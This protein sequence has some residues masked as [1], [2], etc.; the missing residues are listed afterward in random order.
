MAKVVAEKQINAFVKGLITEASPL[1]FPPNAA[2]DIENFDLGQ[3]GSLFR[4]LGL[5]Y[6]LNYTAT[7]TGIPTA[8]LQNARMSTHSWPFPG[9]DTDVSIGVIRIYNRLWFLNLLTA[10]PS[11][12]LLNGG[13][14]ITLSGL[15]NADIETTVING[16]LI[17]VS[18]EL[19]K[20]IHLVYDVSTQLVSQSTIDIKIRDLF[21]VTDSLGIDERPTSL[22]AAHKYNLKNQGW[23][24]KITSICGTD[25]IDCTKSTINT[26][27]SNADTWTLG[28]V[29]DSSSANFEKYDP[30]KLVLNS[31]DNSLVSRGS[32]IIDAFNRGADRTT[33]SGVSGLVAD[34]ELGRFS[35]ITAYS[36]RI[37]YSGVASNV[38][39]KDDNS[40]NYAGFILFS[41]VVTAKDKLGKCY[42]EA[43]PT[44]PNISDI[45]DT[46]GGTIQIPEAS[47]I[48]RII[49]TKSSLLVFAENGVWEVFGDAGGFKATSFQLSKISNVGINNP[50]AVVEANGQIFYWA[51]SG[52][53]VAVQDN[54]NG[55][56]LVQNL[57]F[58]TIQTLFNDLSDLA[59]RHAKGFYDESVNHIRWIYNDSNTYSESNYVNSYNVEL[60]L[61]LNLQAFYKYRIS[62]LA[63]NSPFI[64]DF[65]EIP[66]FALTSTTDTVYV[67]TDPVLVGTDAVEI[68]ITSSIQRTSKYNYLTITGTSFTLS[69][70]I[71]TTFID[72]K[73]AD[74]IG[75][76]Y[77]S[78]LLTGYEIMNDILRYKQIPYVLFYF[79]R[80]EDGFTSVGG[81]LEIDNPS[82]C[83]VQAQW[84]WTNSA[85][86]GKWG[87][88]FQAYRFLRN[89]IPSGPSDT[90]DY[91][92]RVIVTKNKLRGSGR[93]L[94]LLI[95]SEQG[96]DMKLL[97]W[98]YMFTG[99][100]HP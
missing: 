40:P 28:K 42:Q 25:A 37:F 74:S 8:T 5:D 35:T 59:K 61:D 18:S 92:D 84:N 62:S 81:N 33:L 48:V 71:D 4:R 64:A 89:Y 58:T 83:L 100:S 17:I 68:S 27:P 72:W 70:Y 22:S 90:F 19:D 77:S 21:G 12:N 15:S 44:S 31:I 41:Q 10:N 43:D 45:I 97:G 63:T 98:G 26:Y 39:G 86:S 30:N 32:F 80:T 13:T 6:E 67:G 91:G 16:D 11:S 46:D 69:K 2:L 50:K 93:A 73:S 38:T 66:R 20:P 24:T 47:K 75:V 79:D 78:Y 99:D 29:G 95:Q 54:V 94:S 14:Y 23:S 85:D 82:S 60:A 1:T 87:S 49:S 65:V 7:A 3:N 55:R 57:S 56:Y 34:R 52:I 53:Y 9:G 96:K 76:N 51:K 88:Q 36:G